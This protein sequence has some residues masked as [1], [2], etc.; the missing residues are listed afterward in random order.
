MGDMDSKM[1]ER[2]RFSIKGPEGEYRGEA[3]GDE[4]QDNARYSVRL[5]TGEE[6]EMKAVP[7]HTGKYGWAAEGKGNIRGLVPVVGSII[8]RYFKRKRKSTEL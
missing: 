8:E 3:V 5:A 1:N 4:L 7:Q 2:I 6:F